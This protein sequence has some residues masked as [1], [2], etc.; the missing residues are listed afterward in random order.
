MGRRGPAIKG[1]F[2][3]Q[4]AVLSTRIR[5]KTRE[6]LEAA[7][8]KSGRS[9]SQEIEFRLRNS[10][11]NDERWEAAFGSRKNFAIMRT[12]ASLAES[13]I[14]VKNRG[15]DWTS[16]PY[17]FDQVAKAIGFVLE[18]IRPPG[19]LPQTVEDALD[20]GGARQWKWQAA[21][22]F[23]E[24]KEVDPALPVSE[25]SKGLAVRLKDDLGEIAERVKLP[26]KT[27]ATAPAKAREGRG[28][29]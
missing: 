6:Y 15:A 3:G 22:L 5:P 14:N 2:A 10:F 1:E 7:A 9:L 17:L 25:K 19:D 20:H 11:T 8:K 27:I 12:M 16:D 18:L 13:M 24:I 21:E 26:Y 23:R 29:K 28:G 4:T